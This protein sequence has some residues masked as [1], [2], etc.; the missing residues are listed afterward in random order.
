MIQ[1][2]SI[3]TKNNII[4]TFGIRLRRFAETHF[5]IKNYNNA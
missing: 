1:I 5:Y 4:A 3:L 2:V